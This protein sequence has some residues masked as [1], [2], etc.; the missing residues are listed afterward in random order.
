MIEKVNLN[1]EEVETIWTHSKYHSG[2]WIEVYSTDKILLRR[3]EKFSHKY[4]DY[5]KVINDDKYSMTFMIHPKCMGFYPKVPR[6][7][8]VLTEAQKQANKERL[9][10]MRK[11]KVE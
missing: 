1:A 8:P 6:K 2:D 9:E 3:Y 4:P 11:A 7:T 5:C 10:R